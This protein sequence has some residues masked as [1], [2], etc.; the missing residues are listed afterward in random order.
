M[1]RIV[2]SGTTPS[3]LRSRRPVGEGDAV[4]AVMTMV[5]RN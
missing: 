5:L 1:P 3:T 2:R 4:A